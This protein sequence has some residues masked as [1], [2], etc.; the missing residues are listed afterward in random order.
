LYNLTDEEI[1][2]V[3]GVYKFYN[4]KQKYK[5]VKKILDKPVVIE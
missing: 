3:E 2:V 4:E 5:F 1:A